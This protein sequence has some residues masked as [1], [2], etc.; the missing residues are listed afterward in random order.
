MQ[1]VP[2]RARAARYDA[3]VAPDGIT[4]VST[5]IPAAPALVWDTPDRA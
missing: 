2:A 4:F 1:A 5:W 3:H